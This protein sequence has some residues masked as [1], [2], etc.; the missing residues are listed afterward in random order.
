MG[1]SKF[2]KLGLPRLWG[3]INLCANLQLKWGPNQSCS[4]HW[5]LSN[6]MWHAT[7][8]Q[9]KQGDCWLVVVGSQIANSTPDL[10]FGHNLCFKCPNGSC[11]LISD[12]HVSR[13]FQ[14]YNE[15]FNLMIFY[16]CNCLLKI[17]ESIE[18]RTPKIGVHL[19]VWKFIPSHSFALLGAWN[20]IPELSLG[21]HLCKPLP[22]SRA[23]G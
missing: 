16:P 5:E 13:S 18:I 22:W 2:P 1:V 17:H 15:I 21:P 10:S 7:F 6:G 14:C 3:L 4:P 19:G 23:Q 11:E 9:G 8:M 20:V 12:I